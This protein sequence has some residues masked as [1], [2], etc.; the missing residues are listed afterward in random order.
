MSP[1]VSFKSIEWWDLVQFLLDQG[2]LARY[3]LDHSARHI[4]P[5]LYVISNVEGL[6]LDDDLVGFARWDP[7]VGHLSSIYVTP[8]ARGYGVAAQ[9]I[10]QRPLRSLCVMPENTAAQA[11][12]IRLGFRMTDR[13]MSERRYM[14]RDLD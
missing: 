10:Q 13:V 6:Y 7:T 3:D 8:A 14:V 9:F 12:Y 5:H 2:Y 4:T 1:R 11:L